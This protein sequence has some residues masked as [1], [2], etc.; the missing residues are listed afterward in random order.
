MG[1]RKNFSYDY[2]EETILIR[3]KIVTNGFGR[4]DGFYF[5]DLEINGI[6]NQLNLN[7]SVNKLTYLY[8]NPVS[9]ILNINT[10]LTDYTVEIYTISGQLIKTDEN[11]KTFDFSNFNSGLYI[12]KLITNTGY[13]VFKIIK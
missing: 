12:L 5:D 2:L 1:S 8:P 9:N 6:S 3:F 10:D 4:R 11:I 13:K 7:G